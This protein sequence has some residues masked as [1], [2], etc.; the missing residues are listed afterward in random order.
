MD[1]GDE[2]N[3]GNVIVNIPTIFYRHLL[4]LSTTEREFTD[5]YVL[6]AKYEVLI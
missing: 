4:F 5:A 3:G 1:N 6:C 2:I